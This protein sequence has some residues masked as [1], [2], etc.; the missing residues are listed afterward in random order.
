MASRLK[1][2]NFFDGAYARRI[3]QLMAEKKAGRKVVGTFCL[4]VP[5][6]L[7]FASG[8]DRVILCG[9]KSDTIP[10]AE[11]Y[12]PR[13]ICQ[14]NSMRNV[15]PVAVVARIA[16]RLWKYLLAW[17]RCPAWRSKWNKIFRV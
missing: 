7:I 15:A 12:L 11:E 14:G 8:A 4:Y 16:R 6:E 10:L 2:L 9:G 5:D 13:S 17:R 1:S 3:E